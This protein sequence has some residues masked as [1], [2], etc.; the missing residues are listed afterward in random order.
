[1]KMQ[2][3]SWEEKYQKDMESGVGFQIT[4]SVSIDPK[5]KKK[6][7]D[8]L[9]S[10]H[11]GG[12]DI[13]NASEMYSCE[14]KHLKGKFYESVICE[15]CGT[16]VKAHNNDIEKTGWISLED[17]YI[18]NPL[19]FNILCKIIG[20]K[21]LVNII[22]YE[23]EIDRDGNIIVNMDEFDSEDP[24]V[25]I[26]IMEFKEK[27]DEIMAY[28]RKDLA[29]NK[30]QYYDFIMKNKANIF[31]RHIPV[32]NVVLRPV[33]IIKDNVMYSDINRKYAVLLANVLT[34]NKNETNI[35]TKL[36]KTLPILYETQLALNEIHTM[37]LNLI[38]GKKGHIRSSLL[39]ARINFSARCVIDP[40]VGKYQGNDII[41]P[42]LCFLEIYKFEI[43][44]I[45]SNVDGYSIS[46]ANDRWMSATRHFDR[47]VYL[48][49]KH[50]IE[51]SKGGLPCI[52]NRNPTI[53][54]GSMLSMRVVDVKDDYDDLTMEIPVAT[55]ASL[56]G[57][58]DG[59]VLNLISIKDKKMAA[60]L[61]RVFSLRQMAISR[62][63]GRFNRKTNLI[64]D[65]MIGLHA[66]AAEDR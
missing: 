15:E 29:E 49:M 53:S 63:D 48:I 2:T 32:F 52:L 54:Y 41:I 25:N 55:L 42:Y 37:V 46:D 10:S 44:N 3:I 30:I 14:C 38:S 24:Y 18:I 13:E 8:G 28:Y 65:E 17:Y 1:M 36:I 59:D 35:D 5:T 20:S 31:S 47:K 23:K 60:S 62:N 33:M 22:H 51:K 4:N 64:K 27:F 56:A 16:E 61:D 43:I 19:Y 11:Y 7:I 66:F 50:L 12:T 9:F 34:L 39:G 26:G 58:F 40:L 21:R 6:T 57:D 45:L